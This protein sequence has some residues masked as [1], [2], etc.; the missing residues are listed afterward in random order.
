MA[1]LE[2]LKKMI[3]DGIVKEEDLSMSALKNEGRAKMELRHIKKAQEVTADEKAYA[4]V[5]KLLRERR[6]IQ[7]LMAD[8]AEKH[9][10]DFLDIL[11]GEAGSMEPSERCLK[12][13]ED[14]DGQ[15]TDELL[16]TAY[17]YAVF[18]SDKEM[19]SFITY[20]LGFTPI[21]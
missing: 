12:E 18:V 1:A 9:I 7:K 6:G 11:S 20:E 21:L 5:K 13:L 10:G 4:L 3:E 19:C 8:S 2:T 17:P 16:E 14:I 15:L